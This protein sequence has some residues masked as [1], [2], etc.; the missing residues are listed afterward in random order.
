MKLSSFL[1]ANEQ[2]YQENF[3]KKQM[4]HSYECSVKAELNYIEVIA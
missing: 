2:I 1:K 4:T 3:G